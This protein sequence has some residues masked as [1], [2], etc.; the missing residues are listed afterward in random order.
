[1]MPAV[2]WAS[3]EPWPRLNAAAETSWSRRNTASTPRG[4]E[5]RKIHDTASMLRKPSTSPRNGE[6]TM[7]VTVLRMPA[8]TTAFGPAT[9]TAAPTKPPISACDDEV[10]RPH[11]HV[12]RFQISAAR[13]DASTIAGVT[14][15][16]IGRASC[17]ERVEISG[18][19]GAV[20]QKREQR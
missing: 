15:A 12:S 3:F 10:G 16:E 14:T 18:G 1:M 7:N 8:T 11:H 20:K 13:S 6:T 5:R 4:V 9:T 17:R 2:F 19:G